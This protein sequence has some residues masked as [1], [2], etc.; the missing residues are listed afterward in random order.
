MVNNERKDRL[1]VSRTLPPAEAQEQGFRGDGGRGYRIDFLPSFFLLQKDSLFLSF[2]ARAKQ[3]TVKRNGDRP[4]YL[5]DGREFAFQLGNT[6]KGYSSRLDWKV[7]SG[8]GAI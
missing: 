2:Y 8:L 1:P 7:Q 3:I 6:S 5:G 4:R